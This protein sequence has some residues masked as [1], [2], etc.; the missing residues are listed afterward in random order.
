MLRASNTTESVALPSIISLNCMPLDFLF[1]VS[2]CGCCS[3]CGRL[4]TGAARASEAGRSA[5]LRCETARRCCN[6]DCERGE[7]PRVGSILV[8]TPRCSARRMVVESTPA[9]RRMLLAPT[10]VSPE[11][12]HTTSKSVSTKVRYFAKK[13]LKIQ[14]F[15]VP[16]PTSRQNRQT[17]PFIS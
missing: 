3:G 5:T 17:I 15:F 2:V 13:C 7:S 9:N 4:S 10:V 14:Y 8:S 6:G 1:A 12:R 11:S 16:L